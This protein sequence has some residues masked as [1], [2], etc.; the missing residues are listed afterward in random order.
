MSLKNVKIGYRLGFGFAILLLLACI[1][2]Y[3]SIY[4]LNQMAGNTT[5]LYEHPFTVSRAALRIDG[6]IVRIHRAMEEV[7]VAETPAEV[8]A[9]AAT[10]PEYEERIT[11]D[12]K[13]IE[14]RFLGN[15]EAIE[16]ARTLFE[17]WRPIRQEI[18]ENRLAG[19][20]AQFMEGSN[21]RQVQALS[22]AMARFIQDAEE[23]ATRFM[24]HAQA[25]D[26][27][28]MK[29][30]IGVAILM[31]GLGL[32]FAFFI[33][34]SITRPLARAV[35]VADRM[36]ENDFTVEVEVDRKDEVGQL[37]RALERLVEN[38]SLTISANASASESLSQA[39]SEQAASLEESS[40]S[41]EELDSMTKQNAHSAEQANEIVVK[42]RE[43]MKGAMASLE[44]LTAAM[45]EI[46][47]V[48]KDTSKII[49]AIDEIAFQTNLLSLNAAVEA[50]RAGEA[51]AGFAV[52]AEEVRNLAMRAADAAKETAAL[53]EKT[54]SKIGEGSKLVSETNEVFTTVDE[55]STKIGD[56]V[57]EIAA[58]SKEQA[59]GFEQISKAIAEMD[60]VTQDNA[61]TAEELASSMAMFKIRHKGSV[62]AY[63]PPKSKEKGQQKAHQPA[64]EPQERKP[65]K[66]KAPKKDLKALPAKEV[67]PEEVI[68]FDDDE[69]S[70]F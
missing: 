37:L 45:T 15:K 38:L 19:G 63:A 49:K 48:S 31:I 12:F 13:I 14:D 39:A 51:G 33:T 16:S 9:A 29:F 44:K 6:D 62:K 11:S 50:A 70:D 41:M 22:E 34:R 20:A 67:K 58:A 43:D 60:K 56:L 1:S 17:E 8:R 3:V 30:D 55:G 26:D 61:A 4:H 53:I 65:P 27:W 18:I 57:S 52:V 21:T 24:E 35:S 36:A 2:F 7:R 32:F 54:V 40:S 64:W 46:S 68:P 47:G 42:T 66:K 59:S 25:S 28:A 23:N 5:R 69:F 10:I